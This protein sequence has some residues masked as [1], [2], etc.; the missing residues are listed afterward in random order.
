MEHLLATALEGK[1]DAGDVP[2]ELN[3]GDAGG[4]TID[5]YRGRMGL[6]LGQGLDANEIRADTAGR[7]AA[8]HGGVALTAQF[9]QTGYVDLKALVFGVKVRMPLVLMD[10]STE[11]KLVFVVDTVIAVIESVSFGPALRVEKKF[12][13]V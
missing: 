10:G 4:D 7:F 6:G 5:G 3:G 2:R 8:N 11:N 13:L 12:A 1:G 9:S